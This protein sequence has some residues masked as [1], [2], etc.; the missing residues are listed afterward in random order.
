MS[1]L[2]L[3]GM[4][5]AACVLAILAF[6]CT[7]AQAQIEAIPCFPNDMAPASV[8]FFNKYTSSPTSPQLQDTQINI[9]N[10]NQNE[11]I[12]LHMFLVD[13]ST[14]SIADF[15]LSLTPN[16]TFSFLASEF[17]PGVQGYIVAVAA[18]GGTP[19]QFN[20]LI[21][22]LLIRETDGKLANLQAVG[23]MK[24]SSGDV[25]PNG[26]GTA[27]LIFNNVEYGRLPSVLGAS[28]FNSQVTHSTNLAV[29]SPSSNLITGSAVATTIFTLVYDD[30]ENVHSTSIRVVCYLQTPLT[31]LRIAGGTINQI[32][33]AG[34]TGWLRLNGGTRPLLGAILTR[35]PVFIGG[36]NLHALSLLPTYRI[37]VPAF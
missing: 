30:S 34:H 2:S 13:G 15:F 11:P 7:G 23:V 35:G 1:Y 25:I 4:F 5:R 14:C 12:S 37:D 6:T 22:D 19:T 27:S 18:A 26:D 3:C 16:Q 36:H 8:L 28:S 24:L 9:T 29:Y 10:T 32:V 21:G 33:P 17:D 31:S 20:Y